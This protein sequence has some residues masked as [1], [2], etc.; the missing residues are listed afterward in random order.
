MMILYTLVALFLLLFII[1]FIIGISTKQKHSISRNIFIKAPIDEVWSAATDVIRQIEWR[2]DIQKIEIKDN[3]DANMVWVEIPNSGDSVSYR[4]TRSKVNTYF[5]T[6]I[7]PS[8]IYLGHRE[9]N[10][11][12]SRAGTTMRITESISVKNP[13]KRPF[14]KMATKLEERVSHYQ[15]DLKS[16]LEE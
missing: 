16:Y 8:S 11:T 7:V 13:L 3:D 2:K 4:V 14:S 9:I 12:H 6:V 5:D 10:F 15:N 1:F